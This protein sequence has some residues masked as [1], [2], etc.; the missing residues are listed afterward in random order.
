MSSPSLVLHKR[1]SEPGK[2]PML[3]SLYVG[4]LSLNTHDAKIFLKTELDTIESFTS[5]KETPYQLDLDSNN[6]QARYGNN[7]IAG[8]FSSILGGENNLISHDNCFTLG[9]NLTSHADNFTYANNI[10]AT[11]WGDGSN[12]EGVSTLT[13]VPETSSSQG[14]KGQIA[15]DLEHLYVCIDTNVWKRTTLSSW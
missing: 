1:S 5:D 9:S 15:T 8:N 2:A 12:L 6:I 14:K 11:H 10:S 7:V 3:S 13:A 4:E